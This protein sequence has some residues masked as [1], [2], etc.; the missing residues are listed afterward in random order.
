MREEVKS[1]KVF[2]EEGKGT[3]QERLSRTQITVLK[4]SPLKVVVQNPRLCVGIGGKGG[5]D[6]GV[7]GEKIFLTNLSSASDG[8]GFEH[9]PCD[10]N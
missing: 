8:R 2:R 5:S 10:C 4:A 6:E 1:W 3:S 9:K 7:E